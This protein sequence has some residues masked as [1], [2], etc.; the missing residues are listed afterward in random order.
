ML[1]LETLM[2]LI[3]DFIR[4]LLIEVVSDRVRGLRLTRQLRGMKDVRRHIHRTTR[5]RLLN[6]ISTEVRR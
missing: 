5:H 3:A 2:V 1:K 4:T 6:R